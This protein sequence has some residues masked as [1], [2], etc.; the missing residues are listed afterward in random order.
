L[1]YYT[2][3]V[4]KPGEFLGHLGFPLPL[5]YPMLLP[6]LSRAYPMLWDGLGAGDVKEA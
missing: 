1:I 6:C 2:I 4:P 3:Y 5:Q